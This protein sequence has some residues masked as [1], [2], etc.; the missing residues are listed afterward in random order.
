[1]A[2]EKARAT[3]CVSETLYGW[4][5]RCP[6]CEAHLA[7]TRTELLLEDRIFYSEHTFDTKRWTFDGNRERPTLSP[8]MLAHPNGL[9]PRCHSFV[10]GGRIEY[11]ADCGHD[12][13][14]KTVDL[15]AWDD[16][17]A[18]ASV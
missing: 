14:L 3:C 4:Q 18:V 9:T 5:V 15:P 10:R 2:G 6:A 16:E 12:M 11:L 8:S 17:K 7:K 13:A 1:M